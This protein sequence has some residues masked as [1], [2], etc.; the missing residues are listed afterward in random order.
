MLLIFL[1][2][3]YITKDFVEGKIEIRGDTKLFP[4]GADIK[5]IFIKLS[6]YWA[7]HLTGNFGVNFIHF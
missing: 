3:L 5:S 1:S 2:S 7:S 4:E 6:G